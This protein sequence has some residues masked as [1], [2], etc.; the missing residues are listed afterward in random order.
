ML[1]D[2]KKYL[3]SLPSGEKM[4]GK[5]LKVAAMTVYNMLVFI[6]IIIIIILELYLSN[7]TSYRIHALASCDTQGS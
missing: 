5:V 7:I 2:L 3:D 1:M 6:I 4:D